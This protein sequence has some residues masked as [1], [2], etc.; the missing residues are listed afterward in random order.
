MEQWDRL[1]FDYRFDGPGGD[2][3]G[4]KIID[5]PLGGGMQCTWQLADG[6]SL[7]PGE[8]QTAEVQIHSPTWLWGDKPDEQ[9]Q[10]LS[11]RYQGRPDARPAILIDNVRVVRDAFR[12][13]TVKPLGTRREG[14]RTVARYE[15]RIANRQDTPLT[16]Q[17][18]VRTAEAGLRV[19]APDEA[20]VGAGETIALPIRL[21]AAADGEGALPPLSRVSTEVVFRVKG[22]KD[23]DK[24]LQLDL[25]VPLSE[26]PHPC[27]L[28]TRE[29]VPEVLARIEA[30]AECKAVYDAL[31]QGAD[32]WLTRAPEYPDRGSQWWHW[33]TCKACGARLTTKSPTEHV[34]PDCGAAYTGWPYD[35]VVLDRQHGA[36][37]NAVRDLGL[38]YVLTGEAAYAAKAREIL[39]GYAERYLSY[40]LHDIN[41]KPGKGGGHVGPQ[42]LDESTWL[43]PVAQGFDC[44]R[45]T[46]S[47]EDLQTL[48]E[49]LLLPAAQLIRDHQWG[50]HNI[51][52][53]HDS[54][55]GLVGLA[56]EDGGLIF[57]AINGPKGFH[58]QVEQ[59]VTDDGFWYE[60]AWGYHFYT[61]M[62]LQPLAVAARNVGI[63]L[64]T[65]RY[66]GM[67]DAPLAFMAPGGELPAFND[68]GTASAL[69]QGSM[70]EIAYACWADPRHL[71][72]ILQSGR[73]SLQTLLY[74]VDLGETQPF[75]LG[76]ALFPG[77]GY[78]VLR[79]GATGEGRADQHLPENYLA[80]DYGP[81]GGGHGH[82]DKLGFV[83]YGRGKLLAEDPGCI[84]YGNPA[85]GGWFRQTLS[86]NTLIVNGKSQKPCT[87]AL[88]FTAFGDGLGLCSARADEAYDGVRL[89]RSVALLGD[90]LIDLALAE[91]RRESTF[92]L[93]YHNR[94]LLEC[95]LPFASLP[96]PP[97]GDGYS[98][99]KEWRSAPAPDAWQAVWRQEGGPTLTFAQAASDA[100]REVLTAIGMGNPTKIKVPFIVSRETGATALFCSAVEITPGEPVAD[101]DVRVLPIE[102]AADTNERPVAVE[103]TGGGLRDIVLIN[104]AGGTLRAGGIELTGRGAALR[105][106]DGAL[107]QTVAVG[108]A[109]VRVVAP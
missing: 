106:R 8:W 2:W 55:Y 92:E 5:F 94:G 34:C 89:R 43:I 3:W 29:D 28:L 95:A 69:G 98:W 62:A 107:E 58:A 21:S 63:D 16:V 39:L 76:S 80:L 45:D 103:V 102:G 59:G 50:I 20:T 14:D 74:G 12:L 7:R 73:K 67:Y 48:A 31:K 51:C 72:P 27:L 38:M 54:A 26:I 32:A 77:A 90:R 75:A 66:K 24:L 22:E 87:G 42:S 53:W 85:H 49:K 37:A 99:A 9:G 19:E 57:D 100:E 101:L 104:P 25:T 68:S 70:Y 44:I 105:Y 96:E 17:A 33:Y 108:D 56:L 10:Y 84:A 52:C 64:Y 81:H 13:E 91:A 79:S 60:S 47:P 11:F 109:Q 65:D 71:L 30:S 88:Q 35:D 1:L 41:G 83:L 82:P 78:V 4:V 18:E 40:P 36:L 61:M 93:A 46:L 97:A 23:M 86:H 15:A 6:K